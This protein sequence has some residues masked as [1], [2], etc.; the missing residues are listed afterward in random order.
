[1]NE[2]GLVGATSGNDTT[3]VL[4]SKFSHSIWPS[5]VEIIT[6]SATYPPAGVTNTI[7][8]VYYPHPYV[9]RRKSDTQLRV[10]FSEGEF[11]PQRLEF[12]RA[13]VHLNSLNRRNL[14]D[15]H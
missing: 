1:M 15:S 14:P 8:I 11:L 5:P 3:P 2:K 9:I 6:R 4:L 7:Q 10:L 13:I 12:S